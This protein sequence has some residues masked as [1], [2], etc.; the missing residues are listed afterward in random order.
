MN[1][2]KHLLQQHKSEL[3]YELVNGK[4]TATFSDLTGTRYYS[5]LID[6]SAPLMLL[7][8]IIQSF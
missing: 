1:P 7:Q 8:T 4:K 6:E 2:L 5:W 3:R